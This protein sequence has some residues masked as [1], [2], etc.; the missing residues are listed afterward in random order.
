[1]STENIKNYNAFFRQLLFIGVLIAIALVLFKQLQFFIGAFLGALTIYIVL[2]NLMFRLVEKH[3]WRAGI[4]ALAL[5]LLMTIVL[6]GVGFLIFEV[7]ASEIPNIDASKIMVSVK[8]LPD[9]INDALG[10]TVINDSITSQLTGFLTR[11]ASGLINST[12][13]FA[14]N[15]FMMLVILYFMLAFGRKM[16]AAAVSYIPFKGKS[17]DLLTHEIHSM[18]YSNAVGIPLVM[19][20]QGIAAGLVYWAFGLNN[21]IFWAFIT[22]LCGLIPM[23]GTVIVSVPLGLFL[24]SNGELWQGIF[25]MACGL[26]VIANVDNLV[27][28][29]LLGKVANTPPLVVIFG[30]LMGIPVF[31]FWGII[32]GPLF[33]SSFLLLIKIYYV[34]YGLLDP[35]AAKSKPGPRHSGEKV[36][37]KALHV[38]RGKVK[39]SA[40][41][42]PAPCNPDADPAACDVIQEQMHPQDE[43]EKLE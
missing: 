13:S 8:A 24:I 35:E 20:S 27:R 37:H 26:F 6:L 1:M 40:I 32:F 36:M 34:E 28:I 25:L 22:A 33:I 41:P 16:E 38:V 7:V 5:V 17:F 3:H 19:L 10:F 39:R 11:F 2:R 18:I 15:V 43:E 12:Y 23:I 29:V 9:K 42:T 4:A 21:A 31:G 14:A 30:V